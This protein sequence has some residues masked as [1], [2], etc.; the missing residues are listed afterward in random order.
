MSAAT[1]A[2]AAGGPHDKR[3]GHGHGHGH[4]NHHPPS[5]PAQ[6][7]PTAIGSGGAA[8]TVDLLATQAAIDMMRRGGNAVDAAV[9]AAGVLG[10]TEPFSA[11]IGGG[12]FMV[13]RTPRGQVTTIDSREKAPATMRPDS[14]LENGAPLSFADA[15]WSGLSAGVPGTVA[16]WEHALKRYGRTS[17]DKALRSGIEVARK[18]FVVDQTFFDQTLPNVDFFDDVPSTAA[19][20]LDPDGTP[21]DVGSTLRNPDMARAY[22]MIARYGASG[23]YRGPIAAAMAEAAQRPPIA[24]TA[25]H[26]WRPG[27]MTTEDLARYR[28]PEREPTR[29]SYKGL[30]VWGMGPPSS[31]GTTVGEILN[32]LEGFRP[33]GADRTEALHR[34]LEASRY[35]FADRGLYLGDPEFV[36]VPVRCLLSDRFAAKRRALI[37]ETA[38]NAAVQPDTSCPRSSASNGDEGPS[39]THLTVADDD[40]MVVSYTF[41]IESTGGNGIVVPGWGF[42][43]NNELT[44]FDFNRTDA[45]NSPA[46]G[47][48][49]RSSMSPTIITKH[50]R[51]FLAV[52]SP[53]GSMIITTVSQVLLERLEGGKSLPEAIAA[54]RASQRNGATSIAEPAFMQSDAPLLTSRHGHAFGPPQGEIG[55]TTGIEFLDRGKLLAAAEPVRRGGGSAM[56]VKQR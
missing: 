37:T 48:R 1:V 32:I 7:T 15:R 56:V 16:G 53:G 31:G 18:G 5:P 33:L 51:P 17:L 45:A 9:A 25:N 2:S 26:T 28:A 21:R 20:Y 50:G 19:I 55:A 6:K 52:G 27:L 4:G 42:L 14:F 40:G 38:V 34:Y 24:S 43:L 30:D 49:P 41:T 29:I 47:K 35:A 8:A 12:G 39:T 54:P 3:G 10:V 44:D 23:F 13:I 11:G 22:E 46:G 36:D